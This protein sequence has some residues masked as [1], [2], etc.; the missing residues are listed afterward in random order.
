MPDHSTD[1]DPTAA[2]HPGALDGP[3]PAGSGEPNLE[4]RVARLELLVA[5]L[6][7]PIPAPPPAHLPGGAGTHTTPVPAAFPSS[8]PGPAP[9]AMAAAAP[10][11]AP[12]W[13]RLGEDWVGR[14]GIALVLLGL[15]FLYRYAVD[16]GW[17]TPWLRVGF[18]LQLG[19]IL[20]LLGL[21]WRNVRPL[22]SQV[23]L[24][25]GVAVLYLT[26]WAA[27]TL[28]E[29]VPWAAGFAFMVGVTAVAL[30]LAD[31]REHQVL[32]VI[33]AAGGLATP[34]L[35]GPG[36]D[37]ITGLVLYASLVL[38][39]AGWLQLRRG[40]GVLLAVSLLGGTLVMGYAVDQD[41]GLHTWAVQA[42]ILFLWLVTC[43][44]PFLQGRLLAATG[45]WPAPPHLPGM[46]ASLT[47]G[48]AAHR[49]LS[50]WL[51]G[52]GV[53]LLA[54]LLTAALWGL[55]SGDAGLVFLAFATAFVVAS[56]LLAPFPGV[57]RPAL[58]TGAVLLVLGTALF[59]GRH[60]LAVPLALEAAAF[61]WLARDRRLWSLALLAHAVFVMLGLGFLGR[62]VAEPTSP[63]VYQAGILAAMVIAAASARAF[64][65]AGTPNR[66]YVLG[67]YGAFLA[68]IPWM[69]HRAPGGPG[70]TSVAWGAAA[71]LLLA[72]GLRTGNL[73]ARMTGLVTLALVTLKLLVV[74]LA[75][76]DAGV[77][78]LLFLAF[79]L[80]FLGLGYVLQGTDEPARTQD[81]PP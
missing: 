60:R 62:L 21:Y 15:A 14:V 17:V 38:A 80:I 64:L 11:P 31:R 30:L 27:R 77:R 53:S 67:S 75:L 61:L 6:T 50:L 66:V 29:L 63:A 47:P 52:V 79:G 72:L 32:A 74:D 10:R 41:R 57:A 69:L 1:P 20:L 3:G 58:E 71:L 12:E 70:L 35:L 22:Y 43:A 18:G 8:G 48:A 2:G 13:L 39:W 46:A 81:A 42:G 4:E 9:P 26:G 54:V 78:V 7:G 23:L 24:G 36:A 51:L 40:W 5:E 49:G 56:I 59:A 65:P 33:G 76:L 44:L 37:S 19:A 45:A 55:G 28:L 34:F 68:W 25:G 16:R 73:L